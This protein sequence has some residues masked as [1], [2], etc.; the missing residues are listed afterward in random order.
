MAC[1]LVLAQVFVGEKGMTISGL[2]FS[3][4]TLTHTDVRE[5]YDQANMHARTH[6]HTYACM[7]V[8]THKHDHVQG[9]TMERI[10]AGLPQIS[11]A[12]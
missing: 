7:G 4:R 11:N 9:M 10:A 3:R 6:I 1:M 2:R 5:L 12:P 8:C